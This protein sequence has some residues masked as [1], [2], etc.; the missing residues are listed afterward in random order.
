MFM[1]YGPI[2]IRGG[3]A[4]AVGSG[5]ESRFKRNAVSDNGPGK[6]RFVYAGLHRCRRRGKG[7]D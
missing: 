1:F 4:L 5:Y 7:L 2:G 6:A 3:P